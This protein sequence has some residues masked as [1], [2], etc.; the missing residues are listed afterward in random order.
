MDVFNYESIKENIS[1]HY[2]AKSLKLIKDACVRELEEESANNFI[3]FVDDKNES[4]DVKISI[5]K[6]KNLIKHQCDCK[7]KQAICEH[8]LAVYLSIRKKQVPEKKYKLVKKEIPDFSIEDKDEEQLKQLAKELLKSDFIL[9]ISITDYIKILNSFT[10]KNEATKWRIAFY[11][12]L[13]KRRSSNK[14][15]SKLIFELLDYEKDESGMINFI[16]DYTSFDI[17]LSYFDQLYKKDAKLLLKNILTK[18][19]TLIYS[20]K[21]IV[22][23]DKAYEEKMLALILKKYTKEEIKVSINSIK[24]LFRASSLRF[25]LEK[26]LLPKDTAI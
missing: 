1:K 20:K 9:S 18:S 12:A 7:S 23:N 5:D 17:V 24:F 8:K 11:N 10:D 6:L 26:L 19:N 14:G 22:Y 3:A 4:Y 16:D 15:L 2:Y 21:Q 13:S 25:A